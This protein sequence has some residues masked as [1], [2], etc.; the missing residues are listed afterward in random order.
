MGVNYGQ[1]R[2]R[3]ESLRDLFPTVLESLGQY[4]LKYEKYDFQ[5]TADLVNKNLDKVQ[6]RYNKRFN[7]PPS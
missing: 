2:N 3:D 7:F 4:D 5:A 6:A 1:K